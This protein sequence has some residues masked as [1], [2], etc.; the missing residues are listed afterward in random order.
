MNLD[1]YAFQLQTMYADFGKEPP[2]ELLS[3][4][5]SIDA[6]RHQVRNLTKYLSV[7]FMFCIWR[8]FLG[9]NIVWCQNANMSCS[10]EKVASC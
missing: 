6:R 9:I 8:T 10:S 4:L 5:A 2:A 1:L 3:R 7:Q